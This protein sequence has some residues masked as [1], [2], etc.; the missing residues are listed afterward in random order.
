[1]QL[2]GLDSQIVTASVEPNSIKA[3]AAGLNMALTQEVE[4]TFVTEQP[5][6]VIE[7]ANTKQGFQ[8]A[9]LHSDQQKED[10][11]GAKPNY[12]LFDYSRDARRKRK[13]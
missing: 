12:S 3:E 2:A 6:P 10:R 5:T 4:P 7:Q 11:R 9:P 8:G 1:M 13:T